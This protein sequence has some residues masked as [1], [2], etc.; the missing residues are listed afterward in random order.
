MVR[1]FLALIHEENP[2]LTIQQL[3]ELI[4]DR[5]WYII[6]MKAVEVLDAHINSG[7]GDIILLWK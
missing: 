3:K 6:N 7:Y 5:S 4:T 2:E 1:D